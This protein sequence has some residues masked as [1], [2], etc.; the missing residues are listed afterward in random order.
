MSKPLASWTAAIVL[1]I[2]LAGCATTHRTYAERAVD[3][4]GAGDALEAAELYERAIAA[5]ASV[6]EYYAGAGRAYLDAAEYARAEPPLRRAVAFK[7]YSAEWHWLLGLSLAG[8]A[9]WQRAVSEH[10]VALGYAPARREILVS[11]GLI[12]LWRGDL[13]HAARTL[14]RAA[15]EAPNLA[16]AAFA[17]GLVRRRAGKTDEAL[18]S[19]THAAELSRGPW[20]LYAAIYAHW[21]ADEPETDDSGAL[22]RQ[23]GMAE[24]GLARE[25]ACSIAAAEPPDDLDPSD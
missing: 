1:L 2:G 14:E 19:F 7:P 23:C 17:L 16:S 12:H 24:G 25:I 10:G 15:R 3:A 5:N 8:Q 11:Q 18:A 4:L 6:P 20:G 9:R 13:T 22:L 21:L